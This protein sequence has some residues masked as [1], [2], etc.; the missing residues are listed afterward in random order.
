MAPHAYTL[1]SLTKS[2]VRACL[3]LQTFPQAE[4]LREPSSKP[5][6][7]PSP[8]KGSVVSAVQQQAQAICYHNGR[9]ADSLPHDSATS[10]D[11]TN[12]GQNPTMAEFLTRKDTANIND[13]PRALLDTAKTASEQ[14]EKAIAQMAPFEARK[15]FLLGPPKP[16]CNAERAKTAEGINKLRHAD[17]P[18]IG[19]PSNISPWLAV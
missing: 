11:C 3:V 14:A 13:A 5:A 1:I 10:D 8:E 15:T 18:D 12:I 7:D 16:A 19:T 2:H 4:V 17:D 6:N 9:S